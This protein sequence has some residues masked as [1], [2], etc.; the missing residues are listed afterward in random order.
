MDGFTYIY[1][2]NIFNINMLDNL[3]TNLFL[4]KT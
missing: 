4:K 3:K 1:Y 2:Q